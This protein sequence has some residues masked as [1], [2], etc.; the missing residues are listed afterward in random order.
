MITLKNLLINFQYMIYNFKPKLVFRVVYQYGRYILG[1]RRPRLR[2][3][4]CILHYGC[5][6]KCAHCSCESLK[7][8]FRKTLSPEDWGRVAREAE[9]LGAIIFGVQGGEPLI[10]S[11]L[12]ETIK[13][14]EIRLLL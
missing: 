12:G 2:Y 4:D 7:N 14:E 13:E 1:G 3:V 5:N 11:K 8:M 6:L 10:Y 9:K